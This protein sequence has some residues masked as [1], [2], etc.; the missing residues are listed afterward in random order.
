M[1]KNYF[2]CGL[3]FNENDL[4]DEA[5]IVK[6]TSLKDYLSKGFK[7]RSKHT[8]LLCFDTLEEATTFSCQD[9]R[10]EGC[11]TQLFLD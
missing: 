8:L 4:V 5:I 11:N 7:G 6:C 10:V 3:H 9:T 1:K 2:Y